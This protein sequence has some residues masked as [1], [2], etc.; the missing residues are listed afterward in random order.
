MKVDDPRNLRLAELRAEEA[1]E[2]RR[3]Q[4]MTNA[5]EIRNDEVRLSQAEA[6]NERADE[7]MRTHGTDYPTAVREVVRLS[8]NGT[9]EPTTEQVERYMKAHDISDFGTALREVISGQQTRAVG[10]NG[11][12]GTSAD[13]NSEL[14]EVLKARGYDA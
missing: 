4:S 9:W 7:Y 5:S 2:N 3:E 8:E 13:E 1:A 10:S 12:G 14:A 6:I 11:T